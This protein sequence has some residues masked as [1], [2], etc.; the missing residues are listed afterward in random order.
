MKAVTAKTLRRGFAG[1]ILTIAA[2]IVRHSL[3]K[4]FKA[5]GHLSRGAVI[6]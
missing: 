6:L 1:L 5:S 3:S 2:C 4:V